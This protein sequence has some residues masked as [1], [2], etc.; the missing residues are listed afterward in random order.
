MKAVEKAYDEELSRFCR[1]F[2]TETLTA[3][4]VNETFERRWK[5]RKLKLDW[6]KVALLKI[7]QD[8]T[9]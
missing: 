8:D 5:R 6:I 7:I 3:D 4:G 9:S 1:E 2:F